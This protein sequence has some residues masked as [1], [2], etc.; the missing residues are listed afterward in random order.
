MA[1]ARLIKRK[2]GIP[3]VSDN[4]ASENLISEMHELKTLRI[5]YEVGGH[6]DKILES[7]FIILSPGVPNNSEIVKKIESAGIPIF[8]EIELASWYFN[9]RI[10]AITGSNGKTTTATLIGEVLTTAGIKNVVCGNIGNPFADIVDE[11]GDDGYAVVEVSN[12]QL[13]RIEEF[14]PRVAIILNLTPDHLD[15]YNSFDDYVQAKYRIAENQGPEDYLILN[16]DDS[17]IDLDRI[18]TSAQTLYFSAIKELPAGVFQ[19]GKTLSGAF[20]GEKTD[21]KKLDIVDVDQIRIPGPHNLLNAAASALASL[22]VGVKPIDIAETLRKFPGVEHRLEDVVI[23]SGVR[24]VND[25]KATNVDAVCY[26]LKSFDNPIYLI[27]GGRDKDSDF[28]PMITAGRDQIR[29]IILIGEARDKMF[30]V[31]GKEFP[32]QFASSMEDAV[33]KAYKAASENDIVLLSPACAS[34][35]MF[36]NFEHRGQAFKDAVAKLKNNNHPAK[37]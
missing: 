3:F 11:I 12:F 32:I 31:L 5:D 17:V 24:F 13:E 30:E 37:V 36:N 27:A 34:F 7:D 14:K 19:R 8:S 26:A 6:T 9:G 2:G 18:K 29:E 22:L 16:Q 15:R 23:V 33:Q 21:N 25:S 28:S 1:A 20:G 35:D 4:K 10:I